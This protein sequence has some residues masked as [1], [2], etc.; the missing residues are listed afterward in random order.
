MSTETNSTPKNYSKQSVIATAIL[1]VVVSGNYM[2]TSSGSN[3]RTVDF[4]S[5]FAMGMLA[6]VL[7]TQIILLVRQKREG[8]AE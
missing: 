2:R 3:I 5:V 1:L 4:V 7:L 8:K 6:G